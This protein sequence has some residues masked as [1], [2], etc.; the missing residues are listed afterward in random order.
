MFESFK[1]TTPYPLY[2]FF[3]F[4][5]TFM[6]FPSLTLTTK[7]SLGGTWTSIIMLL[8]Y[9]IGDFLGKLIGDFRGSF[10]ARSIAYLLFCR[11]FF[12]YTIPL[13]DKQFTQEDHLLNNNIFP[14]FNQVIFAFTNGL[15]ISKFNVM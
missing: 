3:D 8:M 12:F 9:N 6:L 13:M 1:A 10:N 7:T 5:M 11:L 14:F 15:V 2:I 4:V